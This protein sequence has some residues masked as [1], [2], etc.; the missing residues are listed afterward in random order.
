[1][2]RGGEPPDT[3]LIFADWAVRRGFGGRILV[4]MLLRVVVTAGVRF[5]LLIDFKAGG[6]ALDVL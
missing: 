2:V 6:H 5:V 4:R 1:M 3:A